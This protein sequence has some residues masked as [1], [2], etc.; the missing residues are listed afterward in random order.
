MICGED[1]MAQGTQQNAHYA[2]QQA[3]AFHQQGELA[4][5]KSL[6]KQALKKN[7][8]LIQAYNLLGVAMMQ[9]GHIELG[10]D[11]LKKALKI[12]P[13]YIDAL[14]NL[15]NGYRF[16]SRLS[17]AVAAYSNALKIN[18]EHQDALNN[19]A[20]A[21]QS[22]GRVQDA[23]TDFKN[24][25]QLNSDNAEYYFNLGTVLYE[26]KSFEE[27]VLAFELALEIDDTSAAIFNNYGHALDA[28]GRYDDALSAYDKSLSLDPHYIR[29]LV[30][31]GLTYIHLER[32]DEA[33]DYF[34]RALLEQSD[35]G[36]AQFNKGLCLMK[37]G[38]NEDALLCWAPLAA[39][40]KNANF[41]LVMAQAHQA[42]GHL[43]EAESFAS[44]ASGYDPNSL[45]ARALKAQ[46]AYQRADWAQA[47]TL[48]SDILTAQADHPS[49]LRLSAELALVKEDYA[50]GWEVLKRIYDTSLASHAFADVPIWTGQSLVGKRIYVH[51]LS[52][53]GLS[54]MLC[55]L[56]E[57]LARGG[58]HVFYAPP[59]HLFFVHK[60][61]NGITIIRDGD[62]I[63]CDYQ[64]HLAAL[65]FYLEINASS[66]PH[67]A[68][69]LYA[70]AARSAAWRTKLGA[71]G[72]KIGIAWRSDHRERAGYASLALPLFER[73]A[74]LE[75]V[76]LINLHRGVDQEQLKAF[77]PSVPIQF[78]GALY[79]KG[80]DA[81]ADAAAVMDCCDL[82]I[83]ADH[84]L[85]HLAGALARPVWVLA[86]H[87][88]QWP[89]MRERTDS[90]WYPT[91][92]IFRQTDMNDWSTPLKA[93]E[94]LLVSLL[95]INV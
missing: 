11:H 37:Q 16:L 61:L 8:K 41:A 12:D 63:E 20:L 52:D 76:R 83:T 40:E 87:A 44:Q 92:A 50:R 80:P 33:L 86:S 46:C 74:A 23:L 47:E 75:H 45:E 2:L 69:Y 39:H 13:T 14:V 58:A 34:E 65:P 5:A 22:I 95:G 9:T 53:D 1:D 94:D 32:F 57:S 48:C 38:R 42:L 72:C 10:I 90:P 93:V 55:R 89:W 67:D 17:D 27:A 82:I 18:P 3:I 29:A 79:D 43:D 59:A 19:R 62:A 25:I 85:A 84:A 35:H 15:G 64:T 91:A 71:E 78:C 26:S 77:A 24:L 56:L 4:Q 70:D 31:K 21:Y 28:M 73:L 60:S 49:M 30:N 81:Y 6:Y 88:P 36:V 54:F 68:P 51:G 66:I 7:P